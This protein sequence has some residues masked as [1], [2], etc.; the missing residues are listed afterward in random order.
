VRKNDED[1]LTL[2][3]LKYNNFK[4]LLDEPT[5][6]SLTWNHLGDKGVEHLADSLQANNKLT[7]L[8]L[9]INFATN[10]SA[11]SQ[12][13]IKAALQRNISLA[14]K[15]KIRLPSKGPTNRASA[16]APLMPEVLQ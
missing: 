9:S 5:N 1:R 12:N 7:S 16:A 15:S 4:T 10:K 14:V 3:Q 11:Q 6:H 8:R 2:S 13:C